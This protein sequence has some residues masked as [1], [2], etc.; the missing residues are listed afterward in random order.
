MK[1]KVYIAARFNERDRL[2]REVARPLARAGYEITSSWLSY[3]KGSSPLGA[4]ELAVQPELGT[5]HAITC[6]SDVKR[7]DTVV[8]FTAQPSSTGGL[9]TEVGMALAWGKPVYVVGP[10]LNI[11]HT[12][13][14]L[15]HYPDANTFLKAWGCAPA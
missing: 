1:P 11:F 10:A 9:H 12:L 14:E 13:P 4:E 15:T 3:P 6:M 5:E 7:A 8:V 2:L